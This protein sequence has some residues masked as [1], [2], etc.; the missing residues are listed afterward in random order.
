MTQFE[1]LKQDVARIFDAEPIEHHP[2]CNR[3][4]EGV[5][6]V[7]EV[8][9]ASLQIYHVV[10][11]F[12]RFLSAILTQIA[13]YRIRMPLVDN[14][15]EEHGHLKAAH[16]HSVTYETFLRGIGLTDEQIVSSK[17]IT[18]VIA[19]NRAI[20]DLCLHHNWVEGIGA[21]GVTEEIVAR[22]SPIVGRFAVNTFESNRKELVH[23][24]SHEVLDITHANEIYEI[25]APFYAGA[26]KESIQ[27]G[28]EL[29]LYYHKR[30]YADILVYASTLT[31]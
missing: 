14:L 3:M 16:V 2:F 10:R 22:V 6:T 18:P 12:P 27:R 20:T 31:A 4:A 11:H 29:G 26:E 24:T 9:T 1:E 5:M 21:L 30:L 25:A 13:D 8:R 23:F 19:Y 7:E 15:Y 17:P 28:F